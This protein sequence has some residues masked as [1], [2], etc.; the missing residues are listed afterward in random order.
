MEYCLVFWKISGSNQPRRNKYL[1][2][3]SSRRFLFANLAHFGPLWSLES[4]LENWPNTWLSGK[5][6]QEP[7]AFKACSH[8]LFPKLKTSARRRRNGTY[9]RWSRFWICDVCD[10]RGRGRWL[11][12]WKPCKS[13]SKLVAAWKASMTFCLL[14]SLY[15]NLV[16]FFLI[17]KSHK[18]T[19]S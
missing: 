5:V 11:A 10:R 4:R 15:F 9:C 13:L 8:L 3:A 17:Y 19:W 18:E 16:I 7:K 6:F 12:R 2:G 1:F 14:K